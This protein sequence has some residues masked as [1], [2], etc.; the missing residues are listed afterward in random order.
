MG[1]CRR[2][3]GRGYGGPIRSGGRAPPMQLAAELAL[4][5]STS[6]SSGWGWSRRDEVKKRLDP[7][8]EGWEQAARQ[9]PQI[10]LP[11]APPGRRPP[12]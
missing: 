6:K 12:L 3:R 8:V 4:A 10:V 1:Q 5:Q 7:G 11:S 9:S 2:G